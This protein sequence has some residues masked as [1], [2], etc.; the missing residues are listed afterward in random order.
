MASMALSSTS[1]WFWIFSS[2]VEDPKYSSASPSL[3]LAWLSRL[4]W[5]IT[6]PP[7]LVAISRVS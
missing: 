6:G 5:P 1:C 4:P 3:T 2:M 7:A